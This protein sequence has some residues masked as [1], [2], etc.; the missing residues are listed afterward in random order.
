MNF[1]NRAG[2]L[3]K[4]ETQEINDRAKELKRKGRDLVDLGAGDPKFREP[5]QALAAGKKAIKDGYTGYTEVGG[6]PNLKEA[7]KERYEKVF[8]VA[9]EN[10]AVMAT[11]GAK[12]ALYEIDQL[13][14]EEGD[15]VI[16]PRPYW[17]SYAAQVELTGAK[18]VFTS[19]DSNNHFLPTAADIAAK[20]TSATKG[21]LIN[22]PSNPAGGV[23]N[24]KQKENI[25]ELAR[26]HELFLV[27]DECYDGFVYER[28]RFQTLSSADYE[29]V[30]VVG[31]T[32]KNFAMTGWR[33][34]YILGNKK[35]VKELEK[36]QSHLTSNPPAISQKAGE[37][38]FR[39]GL[40]LSRELRDQFKRK[41]NYLAE[42]LS[43]FPG[44][45][46]PPPPGSFYLFP[47]VREL[48]LRLGYEGDQDGKLAK[49]FLERAGVVTVPG[50][51][52]GAPGHLR[53]AY[54]PE[55]S[56][57]REAINRIGNTLR[58]SL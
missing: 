51:A 6:N 50:S 19:G 29:N 11:V 39:N 38:A 13:L 54:I 8:N 33:L 58:N 31:S 23:Y 4:S 46:C 9:T 34:G 49:L 30:L 42:E 12:T 25:L 2:V 44:I 28:D 52:F 26:K 43:N 3:T 5:E 48:L 18:P 41:R 22:S 7:I 24:G 35:Y 27:S 37:A 17:V 21:I 47:D 10:L 45:V 20:V 56:R 15:E 32:S 53:M 16:L 1:S 57:L 55:I 36:L 14:Y 40:T